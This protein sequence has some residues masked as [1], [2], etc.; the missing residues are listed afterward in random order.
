[1]SKIS[2]E[3]IKE[4]QKEAFKINKQFKACQSYKESKGILRDAKRGVDYY[5]GRQWLEYK[6]KLPFENPTMNLVK[7]IIDGKASSIN[8]KEFKLNFIIDNDQ[9]STTNVTRF[10]EYQMKEMGQDEINRDITLEALIKGTAISVFLWN[11]DAQGQMGI[12]EGSL[13][14]TL[15]DLEDFAVSNPNEKNV[16][17]QTLGGSA[18]EQS[19]NG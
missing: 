18:E 15:V 17:K 5:E 2:V 1:M 4:L 13:E 3:R 12:Q 19:D 16:Q 14:H 10:A 7:N 6:R 9:V 11:E 8:S